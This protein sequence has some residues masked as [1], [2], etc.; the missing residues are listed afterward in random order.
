MIEVV[1]EE[2]VGSDRVPDR[3]DCERALGWHALLQLERNG[4]LFRVHGLVRSKSA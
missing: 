1:I 2:M 4:A 3:M